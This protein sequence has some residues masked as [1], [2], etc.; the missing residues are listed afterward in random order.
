MPLDPSLAARLSLLDAIASYEQL[1]HDEDAARRWALF[2]ADD[3]PWPVPDVPVRDVGLEA[4]GHPFRVR[5]YGEGDGAAA[6][7]V[8]SHG[9]AF[10]GGDLQMNEADLVARELVRRTGGVVVSVDYTLVPVATFPTLHR[11]VAAAWVWTSAHAVDL[12]VDPARI[13]LGGA[14]A[15]GA[16][17]IAA[18]REMAEDGAAP[19]YLALAYPVTHQHWELDPELESSMA[20]LPTIQRFPLGAVRAFNE[21]YL[22]GHRAA[23]FAFADDADLGGLPPT[24]VLLSE[25]DDLRTPAEGFVVQARSAGCRVERR[26]AR[27]VF[28]GHLNRTP[29]LRA[30]DEGL[31][32]I[33]RVMVAADVD[34]TV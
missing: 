30:V 21:A 29:A 5:V 24:L 16:L 32:Q 13:G 17:A 12:G 22:A 18:A 14:S 4:D 34:P 8:W 19:A 6:C 2:M 10:H 11:Q 27:G 9:G 25:Y 20:G 28:H 26:L 23:R 3:E 1:D 33:A 15:G 7:L 31:G